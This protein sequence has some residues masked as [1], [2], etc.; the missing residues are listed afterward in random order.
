[1]QNTVVSGFVCFPHSWLDLG[2]NTVAEHLLRG[3][4][5]FMCCHIRS[6]SLQCEALLGRLGIGRG[7]G[8]HKE[9]QPQYDCIH[10]WAIGRGWAPLQ[11]DR[12]VVRTPQEDAICRSW[13]RARHKICQSFHLGLWALN[14]ESPELW[15][16]IGLLSAHCLWCLWQL[17]ES[18]CVCW[19]GYW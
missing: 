6:E 19:M 3:A 15:E 13:R 11:G 5:D 4:V 9:I 17:P 18:R 8:L 2:Y 14:I 16:N 7:Q 1:M 10:K 12:G